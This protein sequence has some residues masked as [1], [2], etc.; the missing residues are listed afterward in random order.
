[1]LALPES[2]R[3]LLRKGKADAARDALSRLRGVPDRAEVVAAEYDEM[4]M[5]ISAE[6]AAASA[7]AAQTGGGLGVLREAPI[8]HTLLVCVTLQML[9]QFSGINAVV[10]YTPQTLKEVGVPMLF[11]NLGFAENAASMLATTLAYIPKIPAL[12]LTMALIDR[13][14][15]RT[16]LLSFVPMMGICHLS[17]VWALSAM[18]SAARLPKVV[19]MLGITLY[20]MAFALSLGPIPNILTAELF[21][22]SAGRYGTPAAA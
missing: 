19:A 15:R 9:Q 5:A 10:Y 2:P 1:M 21:P 13:L 22:V 12:L 11:S 16:L 6:A 8:R 4:Q 7:K 17:L 3:W 14:G 20:G 18:G